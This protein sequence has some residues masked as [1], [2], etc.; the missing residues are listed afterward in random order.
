MSKADIPGRSRAGRVAAVIVAAL[1]SAGCVL[2][3][4]P[5]FEPTQA[6]TPTPAGRYE[7]QDMRDGRWVTIGAGTL[8]LSGRGYEW[9]PD[10]ETM[11]PQ[12][13]V[14][15]AGSDYFALYAA[16]TESGKT[17]HYYSLVRPT[18]E[19]YL[20]FQPLCSD[21][22]K[23]NLRPGLR[24]T[25]IAG[26]DCYFDDSAALAAALVAYAKAMPPEFRY[27]RV[28]AAAPPVPPARPRPARETV[29]T[30]APAPAAARAPTTGRPNIEIREPGP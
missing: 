1:A 24:P 16:I 23:L 25:K 4:Q 5:L 27:V 9:K 17:R 14:Y 2:S 21:F 22:R 18:P 10:G 19:G 28:D 26:G 29:R 13:T 8:R 20:Y 11:A 12:F 6:V 3:E 30:D 15:E 7:Q